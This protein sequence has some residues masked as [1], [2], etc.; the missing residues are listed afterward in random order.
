MVESVKLRGSHAPFTELRDGQGNQSQVRDQKS[1]DR[2]RGS[3]RESD[4]GL[5]RPRQWWWRIQDL[6]YFL[7]NLHDGRLVHVQS[8]SELFLECSELPRQLGCAAKRFAHFCKRTHYEN[9][10]SRSPETLA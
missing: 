9:A 8:R 2:R 3:G 5:C 10:D 4:A 7:Q 6:H 1:D